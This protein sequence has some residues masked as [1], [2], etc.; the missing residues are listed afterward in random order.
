[1]KKYEG[2]CGRGSTQLRVKDFYREILFTHWWKVFEEVVRAG[3]G[4]LVSDC[5]SPLVCQKMLLLTSFEG[6]LS[7]LDV[8]TAVT[9]K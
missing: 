8:S 6:R 1:M 5:P 4:K 7:L 9:L 2:R 3:M